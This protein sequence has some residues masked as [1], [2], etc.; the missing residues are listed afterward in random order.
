MLFVRPVGKSALGTGIVEDT[1][2][3]C[4]RNTKVPLFGLVMRL[5]HIYPMEISSEVHQDVFTTLFFIQLL[6]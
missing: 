3:I 2:A 5:L 4:S 6:K 1:V